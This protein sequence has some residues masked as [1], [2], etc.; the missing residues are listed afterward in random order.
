MKCTVWFD[1]PQALVNLSQ[2]IISEK[3]KKHVS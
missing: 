1:L 2:D 3:E